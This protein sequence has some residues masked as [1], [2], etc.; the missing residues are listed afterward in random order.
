MSIDQLTERQREL[1]A[2]LEPL[3][4]RFAERAEAHDRDGTF[5]HENFEALRQ[6]GYLAAAVPR[7][8]GGGG[9][10][11]ADITRA[12]VL[13][14]RGDA[15]T[16][17]SVG[18]HL[19]TC[20]TEAERKLWPE[21]ARARIFGDVV[22]RGALINQISAEPAL[23]S[24][25]GGGLPQTRITRERRDGRDVLRVDGH[26]TY[27]TLAPALDH[28]VVY[29][30]FVD[31]AGA[32]TEAT[33]AEPLV[34]RVAV[35]GDAP[36]LRIEETWDALGMR[37]TASHD[38]RFDGVVVDA[39]ALLTVGALSAPEADTPM[40][41]F[42][43]LVAAASLG[44]AESAQHEALHFARTRRPTGYPKPIGALPAVRERLARAE[45]E[46]RAA[47]QL[48]F[49]TASAWD[50]AGVGARVAMKSDLAAAKLVATNAAVSVVDAALRVVGGA[51]LRRGTKLE[52]AYR[53]V[54]SG[55]VNPPIDA[56][57]LET[58]AAALLDADRAGYIIDCE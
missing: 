13:I 6:L 19:M 48:L 26:K 28:L 58:V 42:P 1:C 20:G 24:P 33:D 7:E 54:R 43:L 39:D 9:Y 12:Q 30:H 17:L 27:C 56:R 25:K 8:H 31:A 2:R 49:A 51:A 57:G 44:I 29:G 3:V 36:G 32:A 47:R 37:A 55:L 46:L 53:D 45:L 4:P 11:L 5:P 35:P 50:A 22:A 18:M 23:G 34:A 38:M 52:R 10:G 41:W 21:A 15:S 40:A 14:A 16:A